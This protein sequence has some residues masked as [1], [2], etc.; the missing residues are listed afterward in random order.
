MHEIQLK[1]LGMEL[2]FLF[3][4]KVNKKNLDPYN[5]SRI[6]VDSDMTI[7]ELKA[8]VSGLHPI[9]HHLKN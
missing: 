1:N 8:K 3:D 9:I 4:H 2:I 6:R 5:I 7:E